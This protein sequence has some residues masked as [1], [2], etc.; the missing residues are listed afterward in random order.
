MSVK[1]ILE[2]IR[3]WNLCKILYHNK[4]VVGI[5]TGVMVATF[6]YYAF[7]SG[8]NSSQLMIDNSFASI[9]TVGQIGDNTMIVNDKIKE[10]IF[11]IGSFSNLVK[12]DKDL[13]SRSFLID[14]S[15]PAVL[16]NVYFKIPIHSLVNCNIAPAQRGVIRAMSCNAVNNVA[17]I[18]L[19][20]AIGLYEVDIFTT[21]INQRDSNFDL[22]TGWFVGYESYLGEMATGT[23]EVAEEI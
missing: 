2:Q 6:S 3:I 4:W 14:I 1:Q 11:R 10:P 9:N 18:H 20:D 15:S 7:G 17:Y 8:A 13:F 16:K 12:N 19:V 23:I 21:Y 22:N 5:G